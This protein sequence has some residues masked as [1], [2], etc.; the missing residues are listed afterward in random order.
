MVQTHNAQ[1][2][3]A[4]R[5]PVPYTQRQRDRDIATSPHPG[6]CILT[7]EKVNSLKENLLA[8]TK[9]QTEKLKMLDLA[10]K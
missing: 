8:S 1:G 2:T 5:G 6:T 3:E 7:S 4:S 10:S 9:H